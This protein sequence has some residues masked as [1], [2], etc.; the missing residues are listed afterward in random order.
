MQGGKSKPAATQQPDTGK[1]TGGKTSA[2]SNPAAARA[3]DNGQNSSLSGQSLP[4][5]TK[6]LPS[7]VATQTQPQPEFSATASRVVGNSP[8][9]SGAKGSVS[10]PSS[11][12]RAQGVQ[13]SP[14]GAVAA[15]TKQPAVESPRTAGRAAEP[16]SSSSASSPASAGFRPSSLP[17]RALTSAPAASTG[18][19]NGT[20]SQGRSVSKAEN[21]VGP[22]SSSSLRADSSAESSSSV[23]DAARKPSVVTPAASDV[24]AQSS[25][26]TAAVSGEDNRRSSSATPM[27]I[28]AP[29][30]SSASRAVSGAAANSPSSNAAKLVKSP[31][32]SGGAGPSQPLLTAP[33]ASLSMPA[34]RAADMATG[35]AAD[36]A[37]DK[38]GMMS[39]T[40]TAA[41]DRSST[42]AAAASAAGPLLTKVER[43]PAI[44]AAATATGQARISPAPAL[45][46]STQLPDSESSPVTKSANAKA[47]DA[48]DM[49][50]SGAPVM[51]Y[52][53]RPKLDAAGKLTGAQE[54]VPAD[55]VRAKTNKTAAGSSAASATEAVAKA[56]IKGR[57]EPKQPGASTSSPGA[58]GASSN[59]SKAS[60]ASTSSPG[61]STDSPGASSSSPRAGST[62]TDQSG[63]QSKLQRSNSWRARY[64]EEESFGLAPVNK[65]DCM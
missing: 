49:A 63:K 22:S 60:G 21:E 33:T 6:G 5:G 25:S 55:A 40:K 26:S 24:A 65:A 56:A 34:S 20:A 10:S 61:A 7:Q 53:T 58:S 50:Q 47:S 43:S 48:S 14:A 59:S 12:S 36:T 54:I 11:S 52:V 18:A 9:G 4:I 62:V 29:R 1:D 57:A 38:A 46:P 8:I 39:S 3:F 37:A 51:T 64:E 19:A 45:K 17:A 28:N 30:S 15:D 27:D 42:E 44:W 23:N 2:G 41:A 31:Q 13:S 32:P 35:S 16:D